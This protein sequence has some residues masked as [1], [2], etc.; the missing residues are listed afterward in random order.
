MMYN[1][2]ETPS[3]PFEFLGI[4]LN[5]NGLGN[6]RGVGHSFLCLLVMRRQNL[7]GSFW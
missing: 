7:C 2:V 1:V 5:G 4:L 3:L 6:V